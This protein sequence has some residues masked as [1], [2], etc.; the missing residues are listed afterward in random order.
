[1]HGQADVI[2]CSRDAA[3]W[4]LR[5]AN[6]MRITIFIAVLSTPYS[7]TRYLVVFALTCC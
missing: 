1:M 4:D 2:Y 6:N 3:Q 5:I 7:Q